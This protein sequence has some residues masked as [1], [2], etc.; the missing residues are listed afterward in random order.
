MVKLQ[1]YSTYRQFYPT[2]NPTT[3]AN[4]EP[5]SFSDWLPDPA[6]DEGWATE[7]VLQRPSHQDNGL[8][9]ATAITQGK[10]RAV[11]D[12]SYNPESNTGAA[13]FVL[14][15]NDP[16]KQ[17]QLGLEPH[18]RQAPGTGTIPTPKRAG[19][20]HRSFVNSLGHLQ[21]PPH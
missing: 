4:A 1:S 13:A 9:V 19:R 15:G 12:G 21:D 16:R 10:G 20:H 7:A 17:I 18:S 8:N 11:C 2:A 6:T 3:P 5:K 14:H